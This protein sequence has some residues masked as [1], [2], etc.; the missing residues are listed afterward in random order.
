MSWEAVERRFRET[1]V[2]LRL[3]EGPWFRIEVGRGLARER[4]RAERIELAPGDAEVQVLDTDRERQQVLLLVTDTDGWRKPLKRKILCGRDERFLFVV[5]V[6]NPFGMA[7]NSVAAAHEALKPAE[8]REAGERGRW[9]RQG[10]WFFV[11]YPWIPLDST[12]ARKRVRLGLPNPHVVQ[13]LWGNPS[14][15]GGGFGS[16]R[17]EIRPVFARGF[18]RHRDHKPLHLRVWHR[19]YRNSAGQAPGTFYD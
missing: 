6:P 4:A 8:I 9:L 10:E 7:V 13:Y 16:W 19:V 17:R 1:G 14:D 15:L 18:V 2:P 12:G 11:P 3:V 5:T